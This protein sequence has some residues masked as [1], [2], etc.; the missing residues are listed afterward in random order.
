MKKIY[1]VFFLSVFILLTAVSANAQSYWQKSAAVAGKIPTAKAVARLSFPKEFKLFNLDLAS[2]KQELFKV[3]DN[4]QRH[5]TVISL[6]NTDGGIEQF[7]VVEASNFEPALQARF[8]QIRAFSG[9]GITDP[10]ATLKL[11][12]SPQ[13]IATMIFRADKPAEFIEPYSADHTVYSV[14]HSYRPAGALPWLCSTADEHLAEGL[15]GE[16]NTHRPESNDGILR[17]MRLAQSC[18]GEYAN[19]FGASTAGTAA[20]QAIVLAAYNATLTRC[21]GCYEKDLAVH[22]NLIPTTT[23]VIFYDPSTDPYSTN[24]NQWNGQLLTTLKNIIG[25]ANF[26]IGHMFGASG[27]GGN[28]GC[29]GCVCGNGT[30]TATYKGSGITSPADAIPE[31]DNFDIDY[32][33]HEVGHQMGGNH[34]F[35]FQSEGGTLATSAQREVGSGISI[36]GYAGITGATDDSVHSI[37]YYHEYTIFQIQTNLATKTCPV[38]TVITPNNA[39]PVLAPV[40][41]YTIPI[42]TPF[43]LTASATDAN[44]ADVL[45]YQWEENDPSTS[46]TGTNSGA[47][48]NK[49]SGPN[50]LSF[51]PTIS[52]TRYFP[53]LSTVLTGASL[54][55]SLGGAGS[56]S[57]EALSS[58]A[59]TLAFR[60]TVRDN[61]AYSST[62]PVAVGQTA[63]TDMVVTVDASGPFLITSQNTAVTY[64]GNSTQT[65][66]WSV[67]GT[68]VA[69]V[70]ATNVKISWSSDAGGT[71]PI[72][73][74]ASTAND[75]TENVTIPAGATTTGR[76]KVEAIGNIFFDINNANITV[77][78]SPTTDF[79]F[80]ASATST[81]ACPAGTPTVTIPVTVTGTP[82]PVTF[83]ATAG[84]PAGA[85]VTFAPNPLTG[86]GNTVATLNNASTV[87]AGTYNITVTGTAGTITHTTMITFVITAGTPPNAGTV[88]NQTVCAPAAATFTVSSTTPGAAYQWQVSTAGAGGPY[89][90]VT[91]G[92][93][94]TT[95]TYNTGATTA[96]MNGY[97]YHVIVSTFCGGSVTS[98]NATLTVNTAAAITSGPT[99]ATQS[100]CTGNTATFTVAA[101]GTGATYQWQSSPTGAAGTFVNVST[102]TGANTNTYTTGAITAASDAF[103]RVIVTTTTCAGTVT[104]STATIT[105]STTTAIA[106]AGQPNSQTVCAPA[107]ATFT[108]TATGTGNTYQWQVSTTGVGGPYT[109]VTTGTGGTTNSYNTGATTAAVSGYAYHVVVTGQCNTVTSNNVTLTVNTA[110]AIAAAG[111]PAAQTVCSG[112]A[113]TFTAA[114]TGTGATYQWQVSTTGAGGPYTN[115][116][117]GTGGTTNTYTTAVTTPAMNGY[118]YHV[119]VTTTACPGTVTSNNVL[120]TVN[121]TATISAG[122][123]PTDQSACVPNTAAFSVT[124]TGTGLSYQWQVST[125][126]GATYT[127]Y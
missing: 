39:T 123:Q 122:G 35:T 82:G 106:A 87:P 11:S 31:G 59:R 42:S 117:T 70:G 121:T 44:A 45:T 77:T 3:T 62:A 12:I 53:R 68:N 71:F 80:G 60:C 107:A 22:L 18:N 49:P 67:N 72:V 90:N 95:N 15:A 83:A 92:T 125:D 25:D 100:V 116:T 41:N 20:D 103:Y 37:P 96:A 19:Y 75:G 40:A 104:S 13:G 29:I 69:P 1:S 66:T 6:P 74:L 108:V 32:V 114:A 50:W 65:V 43:A 8:P 46:Q 120:L 98:N 27:G 124:A 54:T 113:A 5:T 64:A 56:I 73:L 10:S 30:T 58:V 99:P 28:A 109:N 85:T 101:T 24:L 78:A 36:M 33:V 79:A 93:G 61:H 16:V 84:V 76:I 81:S 55:P 57:V 23:D 34:T 112:T 47:R 14:F 115:V 51:N 91:T 63:F 102:G 88:A 2:I 105:I 94:G 86:A 52:P 4:A 126:G 9:Q 48:A 97:A 127:Q 118:Y 111:Q 21:N 17:V 119:V 89:T 110:A 38:T 26:D 7:Q